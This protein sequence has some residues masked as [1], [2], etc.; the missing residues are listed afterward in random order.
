LKQLVGSPISTDDKVMNFA[1]ILLAIIAVVL[2]YQGNRFLRDVRAVRRELSGGRSLHELND[3]V[4]ET[5]DRLLSDFDEISS[6]LDEKIQT[7][8]K[9]NKEAETAAG[10]LE[11]VLKSER[12]K[13]LEERGILFAIDVDK[14]KGEKDRNKRMA[15][16]LRDGASVEEVARITEASVREVELV[17][18]LVRRREEERA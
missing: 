1:A 7:L 8:E 12:L 10:R 4:H 6:K 13:T 9:L 3:M 18:L 11:A 14:E 17:K 5:R 2:L 16:L 15:E